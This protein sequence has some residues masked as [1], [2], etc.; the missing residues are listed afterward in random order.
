MHQGSNSLLCLLLPTSVILSSALLS[1]RALRLIV[2]PSHMQPYLQD[3]TKTGWDREFQLRSFLVMIRSLLVEGGAL[4][5]MDNFSTD[6]TEQE[7]REA[8]DR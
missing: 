2:D 3:L 8:F 1:T 5:D 7:A 6:Y 4:V